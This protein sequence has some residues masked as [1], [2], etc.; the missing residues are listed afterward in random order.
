MNRNR[1]SVT[2]VS[3]AREFLDE[4]N[5]RS[6]APALKALILRNALLFAVDD[7][8]C[9][10][11][12]NVLT[13]RLDLHALIRWRIE[14]LDDPCVPSG[15][16]DDNDVLAD[17]MKTSVTFP[18]GSADYFGPRWA[19]LTPA[20]RGQ[21]VNICLVRYICS[22]VGRQILLALSE[23]ALQFPY[24]RQGRMKSKQN[25]IRNIVQ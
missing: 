24:D 21:I 19:S 18:A 20:R 14:N 25:P 3:E 2:I 9:Q 13:G 12:I 5:F 10:T 11:W 23:Q 4:Y 1:V 7:S 17:E 8:Y 16:R 6:M 15:I 22:G